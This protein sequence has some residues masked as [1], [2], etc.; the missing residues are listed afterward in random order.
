MRKQRY[1]E[2]P[3]QGH[4]V[5]KDVAGIHTETSVNK[6]CPVHTLL[7]PARVLFLRKDKLVEL[8]G[9]HMTHLG[10]EGNINTSQRQ[11]VIIQLVV[12]FRKSASPSV[13]THLGNG[14][15]RRRALLFQHGRELQHLPY[16]P[17]LWQCNIW[18][19]VL[20]GASWSGDAAAVWGQQS[21]RI[22]GNMWQFICIW[23]KMVLEFTWLA[24]LDTGDCI[25]TGIAYI[26]NWASDVR[27]QRI[28]LSSVILSPF[29][30]NRYLASLSISHK[31]WSKNKCVLKISNWYPANNKLAHHKTVIRIQLV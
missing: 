3:D 27:I 11:N 21:L 12:W 2:A 28:Q 26:N 22:R 7:P 14:M 6:S 20:P 31:I 18:P 13:F 23:K 16:C 4:V 30:H 25:S 9:T 15:C 5:V 1:T 17:P 29:L 10:K 8:M 19:R 24:V